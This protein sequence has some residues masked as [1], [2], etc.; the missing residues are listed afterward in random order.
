MENPFRKSKDPF[1]H[2]SKAQSTIDN[3]VKQLEE[4]AKLEEVNPAE[5]IKEFGLESNIPI[6]HPYWRKRK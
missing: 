6:N 2:E 4:M 5:V 3:E 1:P